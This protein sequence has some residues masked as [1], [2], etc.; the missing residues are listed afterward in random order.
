M[1][2][3]LAFI[4][5]K[6]HWF[7]FIFC[8]IVSIVLIY[9]NNVYQQNRML[10]TANVVTGYLSSVSS[11]VLSYFDLQKANQELLERNSELEAEV[12]AL[13]GQLYHREADTTLFEQVFLTDT[14]FIDSLFKG[15]Y[16]YDYIPVG[17]VSNST[18]YLN[19]YITIN[20]G[21]RDGIRPDMGVVS[22]RGVA[23]IVTTVDEHYSVVL[24]LLNVKFNVNCK[25]LQTNYFG[26]LSW[27]GDD[28]RYAYLE[29]LPTHS[30]F[31]EG[32]TIVTSGNSAVFPPGIMVG[33]VES[34]DKQ[35][36]DNFYSLKVRLASDFQTLRVLCVIDNRL[37]KEQQEI[38]REARKND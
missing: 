36:D 17:V 19:N 1:Q 30:T 10:S 5:A 6:R 27:K 22:P 8:E 25:V 16:Q 37:Q 31:Q 4:I 3:L 32:D 11:A 15:D 35:D 34:Y 18:N 12:T 38:E 23:G 13:R 7:L 26:A 9:R 24:S 2:K 21:A 20:K 29:Q 14:V 33:I 28:I